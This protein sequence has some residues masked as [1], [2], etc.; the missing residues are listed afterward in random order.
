MHTVAE[1]EDILA[2]ALKYRTSADK[3]WKDPKNQ[4]IRQ[5]KQD[6]WRQRLGKI[7]ES[8]FVLEP[9]DT[10]WIP[11]FRPK[12]V[13]IATDKRHTFRRKGLISKLVLY[14]KRD[15][16]PRA[17]LKYTLTVESELKGQQKYSGATDS[18]GKIEQSIPVDVVKGRL[19]LE[20]EP[21]LRKVPEGPFEGMELPKIEE[22]ELFLGHLDPVTTDSGLRSRL[23]NLGFLES[24]T[25]SDDD[26]AKAITQ[27]QE[28]C[29]IRPSGKPTQQ[30][31]VKLLELHLS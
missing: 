1:G 23:V 5:A 22:Y 6:E 29:D 26:L 27:F 21:D 25:A 11:P 12:K 18:A 13:S 7:D 9:G 2:I 3:I 19:L 31:L 16:R 28:Y 30:T 14:F 15:E 24:R 10:I 4:E 8:P 20:R 17:G